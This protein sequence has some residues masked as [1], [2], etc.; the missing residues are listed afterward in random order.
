MG[1]IS[2]Q[3]DLIEESP[4]SLSYMEHGSTQNYD[5]VSIS[6]L[7]SNIIFIEL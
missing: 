4:Q 5:I 1:A 2:P 7:H 3:S 6:Y